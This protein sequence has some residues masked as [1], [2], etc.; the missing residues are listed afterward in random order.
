MIDAGLRHRPHDR[1][2]YVATNDTTG[3]G[4]EGVEGS[5][6][7][8]RSKT[9]S[10]RASAKSAT[11]AA[12]DP[13]Q[14]ADDIEKTREELAETLDAIADKVSPKK[15]AD[16]TKKKVTGAVKDG[17][18]DA[19]TAVKQT[20]EAAQAKAA[21]VAG[22]AKE[23]AAD[24]TATAKEKAAD[25]KDRVAGSGGSDPDRSPLTPATSVEIDSA[26]PLAA[27]TT[28]LPGAEVPLEPAPTPGALAD[29]A[30][31]S[32]EPPGAE[33]W[34]P[35]PRT[36]PAPSNAPMLAGAGAALLVLLLLLRRRKR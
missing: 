14:L 33:S 32:T 28:S 31:V 34:T 20:A 8:R 19:V 16:R 17:A 23:K 15:V 10:A 12:K 35:S 22:T 26:A 24:A 27:D 21:E 3:Q 1:S 13:E 9:T 6:S 30:V 11:G 29:A 18:N 5:W 36:S 4:D 7:P 25:A 2:L